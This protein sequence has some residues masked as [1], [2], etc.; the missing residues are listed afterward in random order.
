LAAILIDATIQNAPFQQGSIYS[1]GIYP[2]G[3]PNGCTI[4][5][6]Q[7][8]SMD[9][10]NFAITLDFKP[11]TLDRPVLVCGEPWRWLIV[12]TS[13]DSNVLQLLANK[14]NGFS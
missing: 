4:S 7:I 12:Q 6:P 5:T 13:P 14:T 3:A 2:G 9:Y 8:D 1:T 11:D 10:A